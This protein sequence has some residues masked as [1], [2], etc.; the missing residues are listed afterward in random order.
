[1]YV[2]LSKASVGISRYV[3]YGRGNHTFFRRVLI[4]NEHGD[5][6]EKKGKQNKTSVDHHTFLM[7]KYSFRGAAIS[8]PPLNTPLEMFPLM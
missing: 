4:R 6:P 8:Y 1:M 2:H 3:K 5:F 7:K